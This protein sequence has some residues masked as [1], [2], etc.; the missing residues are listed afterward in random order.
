LSYGGE[1]KC[2]FDMVAEHVGAEDVADAEAVAVE[3]E[4]P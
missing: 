1:L 3:L 4:L 2:K